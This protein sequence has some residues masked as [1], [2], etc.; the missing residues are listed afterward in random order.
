[1]RIIPA[2]IPPSG[3]WPL[4]E[5]RLADAAAQFEKAETIS[6]HSRVRNQTL[7]KSDCLDGLAEV[8]ER[9]RDWPA[10]ETHL[11]EL[12]AITRKSAQA[13]HRL[14]I[15]KFQQGESEAALA[16]LQAGAAL[17]TGLPVPELV[18]SRLCEQT[19]RGEEAEKW[20][21]RAVSAHPKDHRVKTAH[22]LWLLRQG[23]NEA[24]LAASKSA[25]EIAPRDRDASFAVGLSLRQLRRF[26]EAAAI[27]RE[28]Y[29]ESPADL[30][31]LN[32]LALCLVE[33]EDEASRRAGLQHAES[34]VRQAPKDR[35]AYATLGWSHYRNGNLP[36]AR[37]ALQT[38]ISGG[39]GPAA[40]GYYLACVLRDL[41]DSEG[42]PDLLNA[43]AKADSLFLHCHEVE[44]W[45]ADLD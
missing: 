8:A 30:E 15:V 32:Q 22:A 28:L 34:L 42:I 11:R 25:V 23:E 14:G 43:T 27:F 4:R 39:Q 31:A 35:H 10:A 37:Q 20:I 38:S 3:N 13:H 5:G 6:T 26:S 44:Q 40:A 33:H 9:R 17:D 41:G 21:Q 1:M 45:R 18:L 36:Q 24:G 16:E 12:L 2:S 7:F 19:D 29:D